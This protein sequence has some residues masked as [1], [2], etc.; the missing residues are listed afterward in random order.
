MIENL[1]RIREPVAWA[2]I[3]LVLA[4]MGLTGWRLV[5]GLEEPDATIFTV[6]SDLALSW[7]NMS[8]AIPLVIVVMLC[9]LIT[10]VTP[11]AGLIS[12][13]SAIVLSLGVL[14]T[15]VSNLLG[16][17]ASAYSVGVVLDV[18]GGLFDL[19]FKALAAGALWVLIRGVRGGQ[20]ES[21]ATEVAGEVL[22]PVGP[23]PD[24]EKPSTTWSRTSASGTAW[25][26][27]DEAAAGTPGRP[28]IEEEPKPE[29]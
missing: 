8:I 19:A 5:T 24:P 4:G 14:F 27:A 17:W 22:G 7:L 29:Q 20:I 18:L 2:L 25:R 3:V 6:F 16:M 21:P 1:K 26:T 11:R 12:W 23:E 28:R 15:L 13:V 9:S 10:P